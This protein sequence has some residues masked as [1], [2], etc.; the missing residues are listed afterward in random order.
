MIGIKV[1]VY[2]PPR[3]Y[4]ALFVFAIPTQVYLLELLEFWCDIESWLYMVDY[5]K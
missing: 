2:R 3:E 4:E 1:S 5:G